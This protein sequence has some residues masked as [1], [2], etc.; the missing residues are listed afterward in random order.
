MLSACD[1]NTPASSNGSEVTELHLTD[2]EIERCHSIRLF[3]DLIC[4]RPIDPPSSSFRKY[5]NVGLLLKK[6]DCE[7]HMQSWK[8][9]LRAWST[10][11]AACT[12]TTFVCA[13]NLD[14]IGTMVN[15]I[16]TRSST[17]AK[18]SHKDADDKIHQ[19]DG[20]RG[21]LNKVLETAVTGNLVLDLTSARQDFFEAIPLVYSL[22]LLRASRIASESGIL[23]KKSRLKVSQEFERIVKA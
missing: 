5:L 13:A 16:A 6:Y 8:W 3:L 18:K 7:G 9:A 17:W 10:D 1:Q 23:D 2:D 11:Y 21:P 22:A 4:G 14:E 19:A 12:M 15:L 20:S